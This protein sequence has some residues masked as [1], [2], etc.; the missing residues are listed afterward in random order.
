MVESASQ[1]NSIRFT[2]EQ[3]C[4]FIVCTATGFRIHETT[5]GK[6]L[7]ACHAF[8]GGLMHCRPLGRSNIFMVVGTG[9]AASE[10]RNRLVVW[11]DAV[12]KRV[13]SVQFHRSIVDIWT[14]GT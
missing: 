2:S 9:K 1:I 5:S 7:K 10:E 8:E 6:L 3:D 4:N 11:D 12:G 13:G 14:E